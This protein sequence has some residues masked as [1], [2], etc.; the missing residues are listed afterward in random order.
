MDRSRTVAAHAAFRSLLDAIARPGSVGTLSA[1]DP[2]FVAGL[3]AFAESVLDAETSL[4]WIGE[5]VTEIVN[6]LSVRHRCPLVPPSE[7]SF[8]V[9]GHAGAIGQIHGLRTGTPEFPEVSATLIYLVDSVH[10]HGGAHSWSGPGIPEAV[11]PRIDCLHIGELEELS[12]VNASYPQGVDA[13]FLDRQG[14]ILALPRSTRIR[15]NAS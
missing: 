2:T 7:S 12:L 14:R 8:V 4:S 3:E 10:E 13:F 9:V 1:P 5:D 6:S 11:F 15:G